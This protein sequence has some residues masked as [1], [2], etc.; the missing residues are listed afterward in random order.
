MLAGTWLAEFADL[1]SAGAGALHLSPRQ[2]D[3]LEMW[4]LAA[5]LGEHRPVAAKA[6]GGHGGARRGGRDLIAERYA[7]AKGKAPKPK[8][9]RPP[10]L[11]PRLASVI[12]IQGRTG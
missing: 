12:P 11:D 9:D 3:D 4:E 5:A 10:A 6:A 2:V 7:H 8:P 1:Y